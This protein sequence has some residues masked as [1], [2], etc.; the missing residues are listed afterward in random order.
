[1]N[2][3]IFSGGKTFPVDIRGRRF[4]DAGMGAIGG[5]SLAENGH[6]EASDMTGVTLSVGP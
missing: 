5:K 1:M 4:L 3:V 6:F 2:V